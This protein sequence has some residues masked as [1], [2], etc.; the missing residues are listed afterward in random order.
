M[1]LT[2]RGSVVAVVNHW[3]GTRRLLSALANVL[4]LLSVCK[5]GQTADCKNSRLWIQCN[6]GDRVCARKMS[7]TSRPWSPQVV[8]APA[9][10]AYPSKM[11]VCTEA[12]NVR[13]AVGCWAGR[14]R[15]YVACTV[16]IYVHNF[17]PN[18][19]PVSWRAFPGL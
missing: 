14:A 2:T 19:Q 15:N 10:V 4:C 17:N 13:R 6:S 5:R 9:G 16:N 7:I 12:G 1:F 11:H 8:R 18:H 3:T